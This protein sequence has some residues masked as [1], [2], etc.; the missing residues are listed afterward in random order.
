MKSILIG[1][2][3]SI[4]VHSEFNYK[5]LY[6]RLL[7]NS[8]IRAEINNIF[9]RMETCDFELVIDLIEKAKI[10]CSVYG[11][12][13]ANAAANKTIGDLKELLIKAVALANPNFP[14]DALM[15]T[16]SI[17]E[18]LVEYSKIFTTNY[19][20]LLYWACRSSNRWNICDCFTSKGFNPR[21]DRNEN[22]CTIYFVHGAIH[23]YEKDGEVL[24]LN[25]ERTKGPDGILI[26]KIG[27][28]IRSGILPI[29]IAEGLSKQKLA[30]ILA[31]RYLSHCYN[32]L[33]S[34][35]G[36]LDIFGHSL[37][38]G[39]DDHIVAAIQS[40]G[41]TKINLYQYKYT[42]CR[43]EGDIEMARIKAKTGKEVAIY[44][45]RDHDFSRKWC[46]LD[47]LS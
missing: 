22:P 40:S 30:R 15:N 6:A 44:D 41:V 46:V 19:D 38:S 27:S 42:E 8:S 16:G 45:S 34:L 4:M 10:F 36:E 33:K 18:S 7:E 35:S 39:V 43:S 21:N 9:A 28:N 47:D 24:K 29:F 3:L 13:D 1:N 5:S 2:G 12:S 11:F 20:L 32:S 26:N 31:N 37:K 25:A 23:L 17:N 14:D